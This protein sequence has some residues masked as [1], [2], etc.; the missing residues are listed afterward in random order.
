MNLMTD[1]I[2]C[3]LA[4]QKIVVPRVVRNWTPGHTLCR[5]A[6]R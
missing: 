6:I 4:R 1:I 2:G 3:C 5:S